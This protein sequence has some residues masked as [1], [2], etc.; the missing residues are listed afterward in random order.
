MLGVEGR[1]LV[2]VRNAEDDSRTSCES[3]RSQGLLQR[4]PSLLRPVE[5]ELETKSGSCL[6][7]CESGTSISSVVEGGD[8]DV[9]KQVPPFGVDMTVRSGNSGSC[10]IRPE[11]GVTLV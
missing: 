5:L 10:S 7:G 11:L 4:P 8:A 3:G 2:K 1:H 6:V 9:R